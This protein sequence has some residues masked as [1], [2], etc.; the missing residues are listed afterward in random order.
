MNLF[1]L[2]LYGTIPDDLKGVKAEIV[3]IPRQ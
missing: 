3:K 2:Y 1:L